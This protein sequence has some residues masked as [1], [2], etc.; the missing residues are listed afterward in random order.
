MLNARRSRVSKTAT[1]T[2]RAPTEASAPA[3]QALVP[4]APTEPTPLNKWESPPGNAPVTREQKRFVYENTAHTHVHA[5]RNTNE[6]W[7][8][9]GVGGA[10]KTVGGTVLLA[11]HRDRSSWLLAYSAA[12]Y[13]ALHV[14]ACQVER[15]TIRPLIRVGRA[16]TPFDGETR[17][18]IEIARFGCFW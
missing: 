16:R 10:A 14:H 1:F 5:L 9:G 7:A 2:K 6:S 3:D 4:S 8:S 13:E 18:T 17:L 12:V 11:T 15:H